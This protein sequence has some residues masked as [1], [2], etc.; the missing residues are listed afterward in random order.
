MQIGMVGLGRMG[1]NMARRLLR[2][3]HEVVAYNRSQ[4]KVRRIAG[5]GAE[6]STSIDELVRKLRPPRVVLIMLPAGEVAEQHIA[7]AVT[8]LSVGAVP[9]D[10][11]NSYYRDDIRREQELANLGIHYLDMGVSGGI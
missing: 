3:G 8:Y 10:G 11:G 4:D 2:G 5:E 6:G 7:Q 1:M 9:I